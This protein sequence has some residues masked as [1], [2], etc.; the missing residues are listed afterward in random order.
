[1]AVSVRRDL[2]DARRHITAPEAEAC[3]GIPKGTIRA[4][5]SQGKI[6]TVSTAKRGTQWYLLSEVL[7]LARHT[8]RRAHHKRPTRRVAVRDLGI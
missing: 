6:H 2:Q 3:L 7:V 4:W 8:K 5:A 1:M